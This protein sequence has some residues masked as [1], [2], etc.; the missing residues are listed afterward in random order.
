[1]RDK[2]TPHLFVT[3]LR[4]IAADDLW[5]STAYQR[6]SVAIHFTWKQDWPAVQR[7]LPA[8]ERELDPFQP[9]PH[10]AKLFTLPAELRSTYEKLGT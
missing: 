8:I 7:V 10:W 5:M 9:R 3:E 4:T 6:A 2:I 1:L